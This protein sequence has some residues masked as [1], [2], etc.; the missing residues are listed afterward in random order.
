MC[1]GGAGAVCLAG[2]QGSANGSWTR[3]GKAEISSTA[4]TITTD[5]FEASLETWNAGWFAVVAQRPSGMTVIV[6]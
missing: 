5:K 3:V 2:E 4:N 6:R 1:A